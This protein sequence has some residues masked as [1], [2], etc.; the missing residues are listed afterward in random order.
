L[1]ELMSACKETIRCW[2]QC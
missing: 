2:F 1:T